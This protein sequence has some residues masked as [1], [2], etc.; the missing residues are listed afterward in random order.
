[1]YIYIYIYVYV[2]IYIYIYIC[3]YIYIYIYL[4]I[5]HVYIYIYIYII[6]SLIDIRCVL[7]KRKQLISEHA[8][9]RRST[10]ALA[11]GTRASMLHRV[12]EQSFQ[13]PTFQ[14][15]T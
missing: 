5:N 11:A 14:K 10:G 6:R 8:E 13:Q 7:I 9:A 2:Y 1:M 12:V 4:Y 3:I 15:F